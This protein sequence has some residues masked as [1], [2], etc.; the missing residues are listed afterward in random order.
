M[1]REDVP[2][3]PARTATHD[4]LESPLPPV[5]KSVAVPLSPT[6]A[7]DLFVRRLPE[8][9]PLAARSVFLHA[10]ASCHVEAHVGGR[11]YERSRDGREETWGRF[12]AFEDGKRVVFTWHPG[13]AETSA[14]EV[15]IVFVPTRSE[16]RVDVE[17]RGWERL[18]PRA[19]FVR[20]IMEGGWPGVLARFE[21]RARDAEDLPAVDGP[22]CIDRGASE[23][24]ELTVRATV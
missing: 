15:E 11:L 4:G 23:Q 9:W 13:M 19:S 14:T 7:F 3:D 5:R 6:A 8:W 12:T 2:T 1:Y 21:A 16:T 10:A 18:G 20:S 17:H 24:D 22:G